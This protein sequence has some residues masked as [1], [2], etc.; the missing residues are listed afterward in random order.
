[1]RKI[2]V[3][4][5]VSL[6]LFTVPSV[7]V[8]ASE[9]DEEYNRV[10]REMLTALAEIA[11]PNTRPPAEWQ[12]ALTVRGMMLTNQIV[13]GRYCLKM[14]IAEFDKLFLGALGIKPPAT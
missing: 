11:N 4:A 9:L 6:S 2:F 5:F 14:P 12:V 10:C 3:I 1:M 13:I 8:K 7:A